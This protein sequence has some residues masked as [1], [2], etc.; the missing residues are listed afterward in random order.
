MGQ[1]GPLGHR[2][3][4]GVLLPALGVALLPGGGG[5]S[6][7]AGGDA[8]IPD[9]MAGYSH[10]TADVSSSAPGRGIALFQFGFGVEFLDFP[11]AVVVGADGDVYRR[12]DLAEDRAGGETQGD[13]AP[14]LLSPDGTRVAVGD[15]DSDRPDLAI[16]DLD[17]GHVEEFPVPAGRSVLPVAWSPDGRRLAYLG[18]PEPTNPY[19]GLGPI[20][21]DVGLLDLSSGEAL[22][23]SAATDVWTAAFAPDGGELAVQHAD[24]ALEVVTVDGRTARALDLT[25]GHSLAGP[26]AWSPDGALLATVHVANPCSG[27]TGPDAPRCAQ[28]AVIDF[29]D[30]TGQGDPVPE[31]LARGVVGPGSVLGWSAAN[32]LT[33]L[34]PHPALDDGN[35]VEH[36]VVDVPLAG[37]ETRL[38]SAVPTSDARYGV[39]RFQLASGLLPDLEVREAGAPDRGRWPLW[40]RLAAA[41]TV[42]GFAAGTASFVVRRRGGGA[43]A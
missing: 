39:G 29:V 18:S 6:N 2:V 19:S 24:G 12:V 27:G 26:A 28:Q 14:M 38:L 16:L 11:Q 25:E 40:L 43:L 5:P 31:P 34:V 41:L 8:T 42:G 4:V 9:R 1:G 32:R 22:A 21:G 36:R 33:V 20:A 30:A 17:T 35:P 10:L 3:F 37:G 23:L 15:H 13:P 7:A